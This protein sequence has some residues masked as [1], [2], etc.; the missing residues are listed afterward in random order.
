MGLDF[1][2]TDLTGR[3]LA[4]LRKRK[5]DRNVIVPLVGIR[6]CQVGMSMEDPAV[7]DVL[8][9]ARRVKAYLDGHIIFNGTLMAPK[10]D[11][12]ND[13]VQLAALDP[14]QQL[15]RS[16]VQMP[17]GAKP[18]VE[19]VI[20]GFR[21]VATDQSIIMRDLVAHPP[22]ARSAPWAPG[23]PEHGIIAGSLPATF[24]RDRSYEPGKEIW[25]AL[26]QLSQVISGPD[27]ELQPLDRTDGVIAQLNTFHPQQG[28][29]RSATVRLQY[30]L[31]RNNASECTYEP[32]GHS[33]VNH[34]TIIG[35]VLSSQ[36]PPVYT[37]QLLSS[38]DTIGTW[39]YYGGRDDISRLSTVQE[40]ARA[41]VAAQ[42]FPPD[43][44]TIT[45]AIAGPFEGFAYRGAKRI[46][47]LGI[48]PLFGPRSN[49]NAKYWVGDS[50]GVQAKR[51][52]V[53]LDEAMRVI[54]AKVAEADDAGNVQ[55]TVMAAPHQEATGVS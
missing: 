21:R 36:T 11:F 52:R 40:H 23:V 22:S 24:T 15:V 47:G 26:K 2:L 17:A 5:G 27:F 39:E 44:V 48:P 50:I 10:Y 31:G 8:P 12:G 33:V 9:L 18:N 1:A 49:T 41:I 32:D 13:V 42:A 25:E 30:R 29:D 14:G 34:A 45:P 43:V 28:E 20:T 37:A 46:G 53:F 4:W 55:V 6:S 51:G 19:G 38:R 35:Q 54:E 3:R 16:N 7:D